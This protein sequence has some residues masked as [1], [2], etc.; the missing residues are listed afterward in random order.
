[1]TARPALRRVVQPHHG[2]GEAG[3]HRRHSR[4][5]AAP[6]RA[7][8]ND[9]GSYVDDMPSPSPRNDAPLRSAALM[10]SVGS[11]CTAP[12]TGNFWSRWLG[13]TAASGS[14]AGDLSDT[15]RCPCRTSPPPGSG[16]R[17]PRRCCTC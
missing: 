15:R 4:R 13:V 1:M 3:E 17:P 11:A 10:F 9:A 2:P 5:T 16:S 14:F 6:H 12:I 8:V 7:A